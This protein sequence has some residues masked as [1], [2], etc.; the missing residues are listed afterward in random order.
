MAYLSFKVLRFKK[1]EVMV[2]IPPPSSLSISETFWH[3]F[4]CVQSFP[5][6]FLATLKLPFKSHWIWLIT[7]K[8]HLNFINLGDRREQAWRKSPFSTSLPRIQQWKNI[9]SSC[10]LH[11]FPQEK[12]I[13]DTW[14]EALLGNTGRQTKWRSRKFPGTNQIFENAD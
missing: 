9:G 6:C 4:L 5:C 8:L 12:S 14:I 13:A 2:C 1:A 7:F 3:N 10:P 11:H